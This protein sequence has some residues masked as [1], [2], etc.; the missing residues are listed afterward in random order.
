MGANDEDV[1]YFIAVHFSKA[2]ILPNLFFTT[3]IRCS[4]KLEEGYRLMGIST[5]CTF[6]KNTLKTPQ[7]FHH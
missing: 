3:I 5:E 1:F 4:R 7:Y 2:E 6:K